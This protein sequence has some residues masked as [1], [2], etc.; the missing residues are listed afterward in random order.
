MCAGRCVLAVLQKHVI[1]EVGNNMVASE[2]RADSVS[3]FVVSVT[4]ED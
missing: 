4:I 1:C 3:I 2:G